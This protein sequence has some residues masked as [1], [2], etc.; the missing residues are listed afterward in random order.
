[1]KDVPVRMYTYMVPT[2][3]GL[4]PAKKLT[5]YVQNFRQTQHK[6]KN[7]VKGIE[8]MQCLGSVWTIRQELLRND[9]HKQ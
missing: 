8:K 2:N 1:M 6:C 4:N 5:T 3:N 7:S 9:E